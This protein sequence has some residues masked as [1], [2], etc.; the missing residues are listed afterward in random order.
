MEELNKYCYV[1]S[2]V[3]VFNLLGP[4]LSAWPNIDCRF[5]LSELT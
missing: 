5:F 1:L 2:F 4:P 3:F